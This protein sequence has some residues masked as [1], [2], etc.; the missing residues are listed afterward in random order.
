MPQL[1]RI[2][3]QE[4]P[5]ENKHVFFSMGVLALSSSRNSK[6]AP[7][8][9]LFLFLRLFFSESN[10]SVCMH[11][12]SDAS[13][14]EH[15]RQKP[16]WTLWYFHLLL[17]L[18]V[19]NLSL[20]SHPLKPF[21]FPLLL[22]MLSLETAVDAPA[23]VT[24]NNTWDVYHFKNLRNVIYFNKYGK[25]TLNSTQMDH[26]TSA[27]STLPVRPDEVNCSTLKPNLDY[28]NGFNL[29]SFAHMEIR[30]SPPDP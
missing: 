28:W 8:K 20:V 3:F 7:A 2:A 16:L 26:K 24:L 25:S 4:L 19:Y 5:W 30:C 12:I 9:S 6:G 15:K 11:L 29:P 21:L 23:F 13:S 14:Y 27:A 1:W 10:I 18:I 17:P 22:I